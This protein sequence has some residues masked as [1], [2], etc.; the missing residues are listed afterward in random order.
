MEERYIDFIKR[1]Y[2][3]KKD[4]I[5]ELLI[6]ISNQLITYHQDT[7]KY[8][9]ELSQNQILLDNL[10]KFAYYIIRIKPNI[11][12]QWI[13]II[14]I[15]E[16]FN[17][18]IF[19]IN[20][21]KNTLIKV[22]NQTENKWLI[23]KLITV[24][25]SND[26]LLK[27]IN[28][29]KSLIDEFKN[30]STIIHLS[31]AMYNELKRL[32]I[33][34]WLINYDN[35][36][37]LSNELKNYNSQYNLIINKNNIEF[38][39][40]TL[41][42]KYST[43]ILSSYYSNNKKYFN[44]Y[45]YYNIN[46]YAY[47]NKT[48]NL[49]STSVIKT[50]LDI[51]QSLYIV[52]DKYINKIIDYCNLRDITNITYENMNYY[53]QEL[54]KWDSNIKYNENIDKNIIQLLC[55]CFNIKVEYSNN[56]YKL[57]S[58]RKVN[59]SIN[60]K[61]NLF[62]KYTNYNKIEC[63]TLNEIDVVILCIPNYMKSNIV[64]NIDKIIN[65]YADIM[66]NLINSSKYFIED[67]ETSYYHK[68]FNKFCYLI[69][70]NYIEYVFQLDCKNINN[71]KKYLSIKKAIE[72]N[73]LIVNILFKH[74]VLNKEFNNELIKMIKSNKSN[75]DVCKFVK[76]NYKDVYNEYFGYVKK[77]SLIDLITNYD[78]D[79]LAELKLEFYTCIIF[80]Q[81][82]SSVQEKRRNNIHCSSIYEIL[83]I[84]N[85]NNYLKNEQIE[86]NIN[87]IINLLFDD[88]NN[89]NIIINQ[90]NDPMTE[91]CYDINKV[92]TKEIF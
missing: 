78:V 2:N 20:N 27:L 44:N 82:K 60:K 68:I 86:I 76:D 53:L 13:N 49:S 70:Y 90:Q 77:T 80:K 30:S 25:D 32:N 55:S 65:A 28:N 79:Y 75:E 52:F 26:K 61:I 72:Y 5:K 50:I 11:R 19:D 10:L 81:F 29:N 1:K 64:Y 62:V 57:Y 74:N 42:P 34:V 17:N 63:I 56:H 18:N 14:N 73:M 33:S 84:D 51:Y 24:N 9:Y 92:I 36:M 67:N 58:N 88:N 83:N 41:D 35:E 16:E 3:I 91:T 87:D 59:N 48:N 4:F 89:N 40:N 6:N 45:V 38:F 12:D 22:Y 71:I 47:L 23:E 69:V 39:M 15:I 31:E 85:F 46:T 37:I 7:N 43:N 66:F 54:I 21:V 8:L